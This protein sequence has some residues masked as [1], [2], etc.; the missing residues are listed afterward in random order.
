MGLQTNSVRFQPMESTRLVGTDS[1]ISQACNVGQPES[2]MDD[3]TPVQCPL[4]TTNSPQTHSTHINRTHSY[5]Q[6]TINVRHYQR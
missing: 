3:P 2:K 4:D 5:H 1:D 6:L